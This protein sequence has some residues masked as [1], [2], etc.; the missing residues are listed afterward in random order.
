M[1]CGTVQDNQIPDFDF[2][3]P[4]SAYEHCFG[5]Y[6]CADHAAG[7]FVQY[8]LEYNSSDIVQ[9]IAPR[10]IQSSEKQ[11][12]TECI[13]E[14]PDFGPDM[15]MDIAAK[16]STLNDNMNS[17]DM[18]L[19][20][21]YNQQNDKLSVSSDDMKLDQMQIV[22]NIQRIKRKKKPILQPTLFIK[23]YLLSFM[24]VSQ[25]IQQSLPYVNQFDLFQLY[26]YITEP[27]QPVNMAQNYQR[28]LKST[29]STKL[30]IGIQQY[31]Q[32]FYICCPE[33][34]KKVIVDR[35]YILYYQADEF[36]NQ[37]VQT[38]I[39]AKCL[40]KHYPAKYAKLAYSLRN[41]GPIITRN[42]F[43]L[44]IIPSLQHDNPD[45]IIQFQMQKKSIQKFLDSYKHKYRGLKDSLS[46]NIDRT[47]GKI[48]GLVP[49]RSQDQLLEKERL[50]AEDSIF[51]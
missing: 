22:E 6:F 10:I 29:E 25:I 40:K 21:M 41:V 23:R 39:F 1:G 51:D 50:Q 43:E 28:F 13:L 38:K 5:Q 27:V 17:I 24:E 11:V 32:L 37:H 14:A 46:K 26:Y 16:P 34:I 48:I 35:M 30:C 49:N 31:L 15:L 20:D 18:K 9:Q 7:L 36:F 4:D 19:E 44:N 42:E 47:L 2:P 33:Q 3:I 45:F 8:C 12:K